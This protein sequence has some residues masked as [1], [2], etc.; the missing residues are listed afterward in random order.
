LPKLQSKEIIIFEPR[1]NICGMSG[2]EDCLARVQVIT[3]YGILALVA[4][5]TL[6]VYNVAHYDNVL[7]FFKGHQEARKKRTELYRQA[8]REAGMGG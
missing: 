3:S 2:P 8:R 6:I 7:E 1:W 5:E 4:I